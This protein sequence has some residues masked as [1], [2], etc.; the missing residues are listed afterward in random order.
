MRRD[1]VGCRRDAGLLHGLAPFVRKWD[2]TGPVK[3][4]DKRPQRLS[5]RRRAVGRPAVR[6]RP[7]CRPSALGAGKYARPWGRP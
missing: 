6:Q 5:R 1:A 4:P 3:G 2:A 7:S